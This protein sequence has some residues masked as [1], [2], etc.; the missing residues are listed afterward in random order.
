MKE[1]DLRA[2]ITGLAIASM[3]IILHSTGVFDDFSFPSFFDEPKTFYLYEFNNGDGLEGI[4]TVKIYG[5][6]IIDSRDSID[7]PI[8]I[9]V[10]RDSNVLEVKNNIVFTGGKLRRTKWEHL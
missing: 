10:E 4:D 5:N 3:L 7:R 8:A 1:N 9:N 6:M 2:F